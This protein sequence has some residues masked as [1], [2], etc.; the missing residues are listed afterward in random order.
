MTKKMTP[1]LDDL[2][3]HINTSRIK[4]TLLLNN[5]DFCNI[6]GINSIGNFQYSD[7]SFLYRELTN[8]HEVKKLKFDKFL[9]LLKN[10]IFENSK[11]SVRLEITNFRY[12]A[13]LKR[14]ER[15]IYSSKGY[16]EPFEALIELYRWSI[17]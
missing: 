17:E 6:T 5:K 9:E 4:P 7:S 14:E 3:T 11:V 10:K 8:I 13:V 16:M 2:F 12:F 1:L 15:L